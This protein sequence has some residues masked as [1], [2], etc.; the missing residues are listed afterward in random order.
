MQTQEIKQLTLELGDVIK[1]FSSSNTDINNKTFFIKYIDKDKC[2]LIDIAK[3][4]EM[5]L[6]ITESE[7]DDKSI[8]TIENV[9]NPKQQSRSGYM[10][11]LKT[12]VIYTIL[13]VI[14][15]HNKTSSFVSSYL[16]YNQQSNILLIVSK[17]LMMSCIIL[18][19]NRTLQL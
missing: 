11:F 1:I 2:K 8:E 16:P 17:G 12:V 15:S 9:E 7:F 13:F 19:L 10:I 4:E 14:F 3:K 18:F 6:N 5:V